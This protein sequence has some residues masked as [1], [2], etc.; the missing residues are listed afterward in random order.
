LFYLFKEK[1]LVF[2]NCICELNQA[3]HKFFTC[4]SHLPGSCLLRLFVSFVSKFYARFHGPKSKD[5]GSYLRFDSMHGYWIQP[6]QT[7]IW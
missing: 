2:T 7:G 3:F 5:C 6:M 4:K 1:K